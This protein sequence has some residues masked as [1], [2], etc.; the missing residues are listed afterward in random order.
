[1]LIG[2]SD[3]KWAIFL[4]PPPGS[5]SLLRIAKFIVP[6]GS[7]VRTILGPLTF[8]ARF[9]APTQSIELWEAIYN[10]YPLQGLAINQFYREG[11]SRPDGVTASLAGRGPLS[12]HGPK[13]ATSLFA[14]DY[15]TRQEHPA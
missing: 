9:V 12:R 8:L 14:R 1:M 7:L 11:L 3:E 13:A 6:T 4:T 10:G 2:F 15:W 5:P